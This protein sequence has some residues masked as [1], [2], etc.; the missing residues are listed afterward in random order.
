MSDLTSSPPAGLA[1]Q[2]GIRL[3]EALVAGDAVTAAELALALDEPHRIELLL[4]AALRDR[5]DDFARARLWLATEQGHGVPGPDRWSSFCRLLVTGEPDHS[6]D[7]LAAAY[8]A[9]GRVPDRWRPLGAPLDRPSSRVK[10]RGPEADVRVAAAYAAGIAG[11]A[12]LDAFADAPLFPA[13]DWYYRR[14]TIHALG[15]RPLLILAA[16]VGE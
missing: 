4:G 16:S 1:G 9:E 5:R 2:S 3:R 11:L 12:L 10:M 13:V 6:L 8:V 14:G 7:E 15:P